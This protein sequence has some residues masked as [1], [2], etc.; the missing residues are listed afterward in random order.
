MPTRIHMDPQSAFWS[1]A[2]SFE[3]VVIDMGRA[4]YYVPV[5]DAKIG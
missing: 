4:Q 2:T 1:F 3:N 5:V